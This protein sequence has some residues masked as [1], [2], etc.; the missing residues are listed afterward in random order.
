MFSDY[1]AKRICF[2]KPTT[3]EEPDN[4]HD[5][6]NNDNEKINTVD[7]G[8]D[9]MVETIDESTQLN[10]KDLLSYNSLKQY[11]MDNL[12]KFL[13]KAYTLVNDALNQESLQSKI[14]IY[15]NE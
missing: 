6:D 13:Q 3:N 7:T 1:N 5:E 4:D 2:Y 8:T 9:P 12:D 10:V 14:Y 11:N 15:Y